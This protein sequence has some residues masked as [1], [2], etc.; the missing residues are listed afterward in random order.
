MNLVLNAIESIEGNG[1]VTTALR[2]S[3]KRGG[4]GLG[5]AAV[6]RTAAAYHG[7]VIFKSELGR[8]SKSV[9]A[10][11]LRSQAKLSQSSK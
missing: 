9:L 11:P 10:L 5:L 2:C 1:D 3:Q 4:S 6:R 8:G 7:R